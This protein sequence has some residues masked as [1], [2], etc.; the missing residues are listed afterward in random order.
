MDKPIPRDDSS[1]AVQPGERDSQREARRLRYSKSSGFYLQTK[2]DF[3]ASNDALLEK[4]EQQNAAYARQPPRLTCKIC[5][6]RLNETSDLQQHGIQY[7]FCPQCG[8]LNGSYED[9]QEFVES[10][11]M[12][13]QGASYAANYLDANFAKRVGDI[14]VPKVEF[15]LEDLTAGG[16]R[17]LDVGCGGGYFV[18]AALRSGI[19]AAGID[20]SETMVRFGNDQIEHLLGMRPLSS[21]DEAGLFARTLAAEVDVVSAI[22]VIEHLRDPHRFFQSFRASKARYL[23][24]SVPMF[25]LSVILENAFPGIFP[26]QLSG[27]HTHLFTEASL[28]RMNEALGVESIAE[29]RFGTDV[30]DLYRSL[31]CLMSRHGASTVLYQHLEQGLG[32]QVDALQGVLDRNHFCSEI[33]VLARK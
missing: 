32:S 14:Y 8:H 2:R 24:Y 13:G 16:L 11:Y 23:F 7:K 26:R 29:W 17:L 15:L 22:G 25:S 6:S 27:G 20:V 9:T 19:A 28:V 3:F 18:C 33:H 31:S 12:S 30:M 10:I 1:G 21:C 5:D 4:A